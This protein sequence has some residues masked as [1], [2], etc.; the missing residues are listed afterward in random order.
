[1]KKIVLMCNA[2]MSTS[3]LMAKMQEAAKAMNYECEVEAHPVSEAA[4][5]GKYADI[6]LLGPQIRFELKKVQ[7]AVTCPVQVID[8]STYGTMN[9]KKLMEEV[10]KVLGE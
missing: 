3:I 6:I 4:E 2:G 1:M 7:A 5:C 10:I 9:G 8:M